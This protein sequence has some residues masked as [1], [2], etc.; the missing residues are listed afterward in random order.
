MHAFGA[1]VSSDLGADLFG[2]LRVP[3]SG[4]CDPAGHRRSRTKIADANRAIRH[5]QPGNAKARN[6]ANKESID[7]PEQIDLFF[8][9]HLTKQRFRATFHFCS[10]DLRLRR[11]LLSGPG[12]GSSDQQR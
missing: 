11:R 10:G 8:K 3:G 9:R 12:I 4:E 2:E 1:G 7:A 6:A 5:F